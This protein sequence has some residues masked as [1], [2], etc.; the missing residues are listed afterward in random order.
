MYKSSSIVYWGYQD[1]FK[2]VFFLFFFFFMTKR[3]RTHKNTSRLEVYACL[4]NCCLCCLVLASFC[5]L[6]WFLP[7]TCFCDREIFSSKKN[8]KQAW[9]CLNNPNI[10]YYSREAES[11]G[12]T[13]L[14]IRFWSLSNN[15]KQQ[16]GATAKTWRQYSMH[17]RMVDL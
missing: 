3:F 7:V 9:N 15:F 16:L 14:H 1:N 2:P 11:E 6:G 13:V 4:K 10:Q 17:S 5:F 8:N 12:P